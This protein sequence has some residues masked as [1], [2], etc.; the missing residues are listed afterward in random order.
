M[1]NATGGTQN[2]ESDALGCVCVGVRSVWS[3]LQRTAR[4]V[5][6]ASVLT[7]EHSC[8][9]TAAI[10]VANAARHLRRADDAAP[11]FLH[12]RILALRHPYRSGGASFGVCGS[13][14]CTGALVIH[15]AA[16]R[17]RQSAIQS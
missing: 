2:A 6:R 12:L 9:S 14:G 1:S 4:T 5:R 13:V 10:D 8:L 3:N 16:R 17:F 11:D 7:D 15:L